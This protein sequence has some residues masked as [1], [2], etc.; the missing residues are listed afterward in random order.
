MWLLVILFNFLQQTSA[1][2]VKLRIDKNILV[3][4]LQRKD[5]GD[6]T[7]QFEYM[8]FVLARAIK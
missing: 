8:N 1:K 5:G 3:S 4:S 2:R 6:V 7:R